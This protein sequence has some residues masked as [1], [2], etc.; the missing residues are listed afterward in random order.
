[1]SPETAKAMENAEFL[2]LFELEKEHMK[3]TMGKKELT[4]LEVI[5]CKGKALGTINSRKSQEDVDRRSMMSK[6]TQDEIR[7]KEG[8]KAEAEK[9]VAENPFDDSHGVKDDDVEGQAG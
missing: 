1:M 9:I 4:D 2:R 3:N 8:L 6:K 5:A 7:E